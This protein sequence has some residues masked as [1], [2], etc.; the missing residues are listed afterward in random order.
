MFTIGEIVGVQLFFGMIA[1]I[2]AVLLQKAGYSP[3]WALCIF[4][5]GINIIVVAF[6][7]FKDWPIETELRELRQKQP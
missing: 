3:L 2:W 1:A 4:L 5:P 7:I 6:L